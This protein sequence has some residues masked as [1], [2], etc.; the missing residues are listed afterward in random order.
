MKYFIHI[1]LI[2]SCAISNAG[3][4][5]TRLCELALVTNSDPYQQAILKI[6]DTTKMGLIGFRSSKLSPGKLEQI[7]NL[8][9]TKVKKDVLTVGSGYQIDLADYGI[10]SDH[11][12]STAKV[13]LVLT[14]PDGKTGLKFTR[15]L[16]GSNQTDEAV[17]SSI[18]AEVL[19]HSSLLLKKNA[20][21]IETQFLLMNLQRLYD[22][23]YE[24]RIKK[25]DLLNSITSLSEAKNR[26]T[27]RTKA[28]LGQLF[29]AYMEAKSIL[30]TSVDEAGDKSW[31]K[32]AANRRLTE[33]REHVSSTQQDVPSD[34]ETFTVSDV[35]WITDPGYMLTHPLFWGASDQ[36]F[37]GHLLMFELLS[38][39]SHPVY[40]PTPNINHSEPSQIQQFVGSSD[41]SSS[42][43]GI[44]S[45]SRDRGAQNSETQDPYLASFFAPQGAGNAESAGGYVL[46]TDDSAQ[47]APAAEE[48]SSSGGFFSQLFG[49]GTNSG[50]DDGGDSAE[51]KAVE[52]SGDSY[53]SGG[54]NTES[55]AN[56][57]EPKIDGGSDNNNDDG[58]YDSGSDGGSYDS[59]TSDS[60]GE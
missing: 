35:A 43:P 55:T 52:Q 51:A 31:R 30:M 53:T 14:G 60:G 54:G 50:F 33:Y 16:I 18:F 3:V 34:L 48:K 39:R 41:P 1:L 9:E 36:S 40:L 49:S 42:F 17:L 12:K 58:G 8:V 56:Y 28:Y 26:W 38:D 24:S 22:N 25:V 27:L 19:N 45:Y 21:Q 29:V 23:H 47:Q 7:A 5:V 15:T 32:K 13:D 6:Q 44:F 20:L 59:G 4:E 2:T 57:E 10:E 11:I 37:R 46:A